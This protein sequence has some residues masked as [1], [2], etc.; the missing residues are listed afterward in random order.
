MLGNNY[1]FP[2]DVEERFELDDTSADD[3]AEV[4]LLVYTLSF[5]FAPHVLYVLFFSLLLTSPF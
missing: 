2:E 4:F 5:N 3:S 1:G